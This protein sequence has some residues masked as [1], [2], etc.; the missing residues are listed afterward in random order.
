MAE[1]KAGEMKEKKTPMTGE[2]ISRE[3]IRPT[4]VLFFCGFIVTA[5]LAMV[6]QTTDPVIRASAA[7][8]RSASLQK[9]LPASDAFDEVLTPEMLAKEGFSVPG[10]VSAV[11]RGTAGGELA[12]Y[13]IVVEPKG[14]GGKMNLIAGIDLHGAMT[15]VTLVAQNET[16]GLGSRASEPAFLGQ[17]AGVSHN[18]GLE[19][20]KKAPKRKGDIQAMTGATVT[21]R[22]VTRGIADAL[23]MAADLLEKEDR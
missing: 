18:D 10:T 23:Q 6:Y 1:K 22:A 17:Y 8:E 12:G 5:I 19:V 14:Y 21:S 7:Q 2:E 9:V 20:V 16:P 15:A 11:Y 4:L 3:I 13:A